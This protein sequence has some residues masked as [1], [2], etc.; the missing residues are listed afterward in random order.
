M[1]WCETIIIYSYALHLSTLD[2]AESESLSHDEHIVTSLSGM[3]ARGGVIIL[4][5]INLA[6]LFIILS[7]SLLWL[8]WPFVPVQGATSRNI[9]IVTPWSAPGKRPVAGVQTQVWSQLSGRQGMTLS[10]ANTAQTLSSQFSHNIPLTQTMNNE[11]K[12]NITCQ[13]S[14]WNRNFLQNMAVIKL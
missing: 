7:T 13:T 4:P 2:V 9:I 8:V 3:E 1:A 11:Q 10:A 5:S 14:N 6:F 12:A